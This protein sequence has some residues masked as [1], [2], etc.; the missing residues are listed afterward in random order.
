VA[1][2]ARTLTRDGG[3]QRSVAELGPRT[4][5]VA[6]AAV[7]VDSG[8]PAS[9]VGCV[10]GLFISAVR[11]RFTLIFFALVF[12]AL[13]FFALV[14]F[15][16]VFFALVRFGLVFFAFRFLA[17]R[18]PLHLFEPSQTTRFGIRPRAN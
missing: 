10:S 17:M 8:G 7:T 3:F 9:W 6:G 1:I 14:F 16:L 18:L 11:L 5:G 15:A 4:V 13:V 2:A 12:F